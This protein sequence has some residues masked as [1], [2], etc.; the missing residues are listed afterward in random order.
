MQ[1][2]S[3]STVAAVSRRLQTQAR[4]LHLA[5]PSPVPPHERR[6]SRL[7][8]HTLTS[9]SKQ[10]LPRSPASQALPRRRRLA[11]RPTA[12]AAARR[13][14]PPHPRSQQYR[15]QRGYQWL[16]HSV[17]RPQPLGSR[18]MRHQG[19]AA[20][21]AVARGGDGSPGEDAGGHGH[22]GQLEGQQALKGSGLGAGMVGMTPLVPVWGVV[23]L[24]AHAQLASCSMYN[25]YQCGRLQA[26]QPQPRLH[27]PWQPQRASPPCR[28]TATPLI[29]PLA[30]HSMAIQSSMACGPSP[31]RPLAA[32]RSARVE[33]LATWRE[34]RG[35]GGAGWVGGAGFDAGRHEPGT[36]RQCMPPAA[37]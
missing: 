37:R 6:S 36:Q 17:E 15:L 20:D 22:G 28:L 18:W 8:A 4:L 19:A 30:A 16:Q 12:V 13:V 9:T 10:A 14:V 11:S 24:A 31:P 23:Q 5:A 3:S 1:Q 26:G 2:N 33:T 7:R 29:T 27:M 35:V 21:A 25:A 32:A 34:G